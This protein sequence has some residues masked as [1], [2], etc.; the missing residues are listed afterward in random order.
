M[1]VD[2][3]LIL[4]VYFFIFL[5]LS[6]NNYFFLFLFFYLCSHSI[7]FLYLFSSADSLDRQDGT[8]KL[9][10]SKEEEVTVRVSLNENNVQVVLSLEKMK[11]LCLSTFSID[12]LYCIVCLFGCLLIC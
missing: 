7:L 12:A 4:F 3:R 8:R 2:G 5:F 9:N 6:I 10:D 11:I 1:L